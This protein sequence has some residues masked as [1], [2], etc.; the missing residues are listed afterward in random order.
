MQFI[1]QY[2]TYNTI[3]TADALS[4]ACES[5]IKCKES[6]LQ[7]HLER[8]GVYLETL[9]AVQNERQT[10]HSLL[11]GEEQLLKQVTENMRIKLI[12]LRNAINIAVSTKHEDIDDA[13]HQTCVFMGDF[14]DTVFLDDLNRCRAT[15]DKRKK[16]VEDLHNKETDASVSYDRA[17]RERKVVEENISDIRRIHTQLMQKVDA[18]EQNPTE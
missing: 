12:D 14:D 11:E 10:Q 9:K 15:C 5:H 6:E 2:F 1:L 13:M 7:Q 18:I 3:S 8:E 17:V 16:K 4:S